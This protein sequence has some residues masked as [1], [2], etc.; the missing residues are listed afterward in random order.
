MDYYMYVC[1]ECK[2]VYKVKG[3]AKLAKCPKC[4]NSRL[5]DMGILEDEWK[6]TSAAD[7]QAIIDKKTQQVKNINDSISEKENSIDS[8]DSNLGYFNSA[9]PNDLSD[10]DPKLKST[11]FFDIA[12][13]NNTDSTMTKTY[14]P[15]V[16]NTVNSKSNTSSNN[17]MKPSGLSIGAFI[18][19]FFGCL[20]IVGIILGIVDLKKGDSQSKH[21]FSVAAIIIGS[22]LTLCTGVGVSAGFASAL[23]SATAENVQ[24]TDNSLTTVETPEDTMNEE[25]VS[26]M[27]QSEIPDADQE[28]N[29]DRSITN[30]ASPREVS[31]SEEDSTDK[32][33]SSSSEKSEV[34]EAKPTP[35]PTPEPTPEPLTVI[36]TVIA[37]R[38]LNV[39][40]QPNTSSQ[41]VG[42]VDEGTKIDRY[43]SMSNGWS[44][45]LYDGNVAYIFSK[46]LAKEDEYDA[47]KA[48]QASTVAV[49]DTPTERSGDN[50]RSESNSSGGGGDASNFDTY[51]IPEQ[52]N[53]A[54]QWVLNTNTMKIHYPSC[55]SVKKISPANYAT[56]NLSLQ[57]LLNQG[58]SLC[59]NCFK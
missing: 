10:N 7:R 34:P 23:N 2:K 51:D 25:T 15:P 1:P 41:I 8:V 59:G 29:I 4:D 47:V 6:S 58:Y 5:I 45:I 52:Q 30:D 28:S 44:K 20:G 32:N 3:V 22:I 31:S 12:E 39:R 24:V 49:N 14:L 54:D 19:S 33:T 17:R 53:T 46:Y 38:L 37:T 56:S 48:Q 11:S 35:K 40:E 26:D 16:N 50:S 42:E 13:S 27:I 43:E 36:D 9:L 18:L 57:E 21:G 55:K